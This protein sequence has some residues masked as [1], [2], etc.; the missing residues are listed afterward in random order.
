MK[1]L[2]VAA[3]VYPLVK[4]GGLADVV[5]ALPQALAAQDAEVR[6]LLPGLPAVLGGVQEL[7]EVCTL[8]PMFGA[9]RVRLLRGRLAGVQA[10]YV[11]DAPFLYERPGNPYLGPDGLE[12]ADNLQRFA[13]L[14]WVAAHVAAG[15]LD[16]DWKPQVM[17]AHDWHAAMSCAYLA[18]R[19]VRDVAT[20]FTVHNLAFHGLFEPTDF[21]LLGLPARFMA[22]SAL[23]FHGHFSFIKAGLKFATRVTT[24]S[25][26]YAREIRTPEYGSGLDGVIRARGSEVSGILNGVDPQ[27]WDPTAD[28][29]LPARYSAAELAGKA[30]CKA[31][32]Q[33]TLGLL[34][35]ADAPLFGV[36]SRLTSQ[37]G[38]DL[39]L[40][41]LPDLLAQ[42]AQFAVQGTGDAALEGAFR[43]AMVQHPGRVA[44][45]LG[46]DEAFAHRLIA[47]SDAMLVPSRFEPCGLTQLYAL[48]YGTVPIVRRVGGLADTVVDANEDT[49]ARDLA[50]GFSF[51]P[52]TADALGRTLQRAVLAYRQSALWQQLVR[53][54]MAQN[55]SWE[56]VAQQYLALYR[57]AI[58]AL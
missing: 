16:P 20:V 4:T 1:V 34:P 9:G 7:A 29:E 3:E 33:Q 39:V 27:V 24:V 51:G 42:G 36:V 47:G 6:L 10:A 58:A 56:P 45:R 37:K 13:L 40:E 46:Y 22:P 44:V 8:G 48:R 21:F 57:E 49:L 12:W 54:G 32:L 43:Q 2:Q 17:H 28:P 31:Q 52:A 55:F 26:T 38:L 15:E 14:G 23:E 41:A 35:E 25:P 18:A 50:T 11:V 5:G 19:P 30:Q 53:R